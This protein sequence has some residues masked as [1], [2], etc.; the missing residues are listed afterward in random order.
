MPML[1]DE[2]KLYFFLRKKIFAITGYY[3]HCQ[4]SLSFTCL[5]TIILVYLRKTLHISSKIS[6]RHVLHVSM[7][8]FQTQALY[9]FA[10]YGGL[11]LV[12]HMTTGL[13]INGC[14]HLSNQLDQRKQY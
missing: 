4:H 12:T 1:V 6:A 9:P 8:Q 14:L 2:N 10:W 3:A 13:S 11:G 7:I 5:I